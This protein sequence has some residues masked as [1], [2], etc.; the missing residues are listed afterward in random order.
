MTVV[1]VMSVYTD[2][3]SEHGSGMCVPNVSVVLFVVSVTLKVRIGDVCIAF[4]LCVGDVCVE[5]DV[6]RVRMRNVALKYACLVAGA[7]A[8]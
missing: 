6:D 7:R 8:A 1:L 5:R 2:C 3:L 4:V